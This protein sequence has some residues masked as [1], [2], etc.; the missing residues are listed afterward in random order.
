MSNQHYIR[1]NYN[2]YLH[3]QFKEFILD[4]T[5]EN[6]PKSKEIKQYTILLNTFSRAYIIK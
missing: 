4:N 1:N 2:V 6:L 5:V 3:K